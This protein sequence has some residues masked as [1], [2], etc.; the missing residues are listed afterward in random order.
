M[1]AIEAIIFDFD[2][3]LAE[4][5][6]DFKLMKRRVAALA[7]AFL[8]EEP[9]ENGRPVLEWMADLAAEV[10]E[11]EGRDMGLEFHSRARLVVNATELDAARLGRLFDFTQPLLVELE[12]RGIAVGVITRNSTA[13]VRTVFP[14]IL[15]HCG[16]FIAREDARAVKPD[17]AHVVQALEVLQVL[18]GAAL[19][20]GDHGMDIEAGR[21]AGCLTAGVLSGNMDR[22]ALQAFGPD[23]L[24]AD[25]A[26]LVRR[27]TDEGRL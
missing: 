6:I 25:A 23:Y 5:T 1:S 15:S 24:E 26:A 8:G 13:A 2:G 22:E 7:T 16:A 18:P 3:T 11:W 9:K 20:V 14:N 19:M 21:A 4:L 12:N 17:P 27:L 10:E